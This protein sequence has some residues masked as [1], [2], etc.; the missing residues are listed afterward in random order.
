MQGLEKLRDQMTKQMEVEQEDFDERLE[1][2]QLTVSGF[3]VN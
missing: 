2:I 1:G 3:G